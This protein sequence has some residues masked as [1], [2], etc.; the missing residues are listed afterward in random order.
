M[1]SENMKK[2]NRIL[3]ICALAYHH[4]TA[5]LDKILSVMKALQAA[6]QPA[7]EGK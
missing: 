6:G 1:I 3:L 2:R 4:K 7:K 5:S